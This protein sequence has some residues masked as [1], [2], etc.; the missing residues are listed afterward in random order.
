MR[1]LEDFRDKYKKE[2]EIWVLGCGTDLD[3]LPD[4]FFDNRISIACSW[5]RMAFPKCT[6]SH[7][8]HV[9]HTVFM[10]GQ[11]VQLFK[12]CIMCLPSQDGG[13][14]RLESYKEYP[15]WMRY[16]GVLKLQLKDIAK[17]C[18]EVGRDIKSIM[19][20]KSSSYASLGTIIHRGIQAAVVFG[21]DRVT[22]VGCDHKY[23]KDLDNTLSHARKLAPYY[24]GRQD[25]GFH[26]DNPEGR[27]QSY[28]RGTKFIAREFGKYG[29][30]VRRYHHGKGYEEI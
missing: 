30:K 15:I 8:Y 18:E 20:K 5:A 17:S 28:S 27:A 9:M 2:G 13:F 3:D 1:Y 29:V 7:H 23:V 21:A 19:E 11:D 6:Y 14:R 26:M 25:M 22:L 10:L 4:D 24:V 12:K 16:R